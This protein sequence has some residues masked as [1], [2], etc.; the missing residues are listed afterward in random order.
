MYF[1]QIFILSKTVF[2]TR[3]LSEGEW[4]ASSTAIPRVVGYLLVLHHTTITPHTYVVKP[5]F[6][7]KL[8][9]GHNTEH[10]D[11]RRNKITS[12]IIFQ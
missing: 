6:E 12:I 3:S 8:I 4:I 2:E 7:A 5:T 10:K 9:I 1:L 11:L